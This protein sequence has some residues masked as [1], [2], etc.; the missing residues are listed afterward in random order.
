MYLVEVESEQLGRHLSRDRVGA[1]AEVGRSAA[2]VG[3]TVAADRHGG[4]AGCLARRERDP[5][6]SVAD[7]PVPVAHRSDLGGASLPAESLRAGAIALTQ[8]LARPRLTRH[9]MNL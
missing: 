5:G 1:G 6:H 9:R 4:L 8:R 3:G 2:H 7:E